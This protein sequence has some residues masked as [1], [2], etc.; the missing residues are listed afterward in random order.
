MGNLDSRIE[1]TDF[2]FWEEGTKKFKRA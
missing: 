2:T 1:E